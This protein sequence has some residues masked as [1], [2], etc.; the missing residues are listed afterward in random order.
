MN[1]KKIRLLNLESFFKSKKGFIISFIALYLL[2]FI[3][4][5]LAANTRYPSPDEYTPLYDQARELELKF[6]TI[7]KMDNAEC[8]WDNGKMEV[9]L[10]SKKRH[11][12]KI[13]FNEDLDKIIDY[14]EYSNVESIQWILFKTTLLTVMTEF[15]M[16]LG[17]NLLLYSN[18][19][20]DDNY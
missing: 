20:D 2:F 8:N 13:V 12:L 4:C 6:G 14:K 10:K 7:V 3:I 9:L 19:I 18:T 5:Y 15:F 11:C 1:E 16:Y 17:I